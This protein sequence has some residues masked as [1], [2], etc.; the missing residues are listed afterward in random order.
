MIKTLYPTEGQGLVNVTLYPTAGQ[1]L[2][3]IIFLTLLFM[4][5]VWTPKIA[6]L[7]SSSGM[8]RTKSLLIGH[9]STG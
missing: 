4:R 6:D 9:S 8:A 3:W 7:F 1:G 2:M 5:L